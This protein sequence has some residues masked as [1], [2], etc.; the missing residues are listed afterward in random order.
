MRET[1]NI[2]GSAWD[3]RRMN[4]DRPDSGDS[5]DDSSDEVMNDPPDSDE[6]SGADDNTRSKIK[7]IKNGKKSSMDDPMKLNLD[8]LR[9]V[10]PPPKESHEKEI[11][12]LINE[13]RSIHPRSNI[14]RH[15]EMGFLAVEVLNDDGSKQ[16]LQYQLTKDLITGY[17][18]KEL[19][20][21][22]VTNINEFYL[23]YEP[24][25]VTHS[26]RSTS[27]AP[28]PSSSSQDPSGSNDDPANEGFGRRRLWDEE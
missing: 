16:I 4:D 7:R 17:Y 24:E 13:L 27:A 9:M 8:A 19:L 22:T 5:S 3:K 20:P 25:E 12:R 28:G 21:S 11:V 6:S 10:T 23:V 15:N 2:Y 1:I 14:Y 26:T 18:Y